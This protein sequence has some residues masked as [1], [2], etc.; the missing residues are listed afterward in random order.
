MFLCWSN[1]IG[2]KEC[3][4]ENWNRLKL[5]ILPPLNWYRNVNSI[6]Y[7]GKCRLRLPVGMVSI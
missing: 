3:D 7:F 1:H 6:P 5:R 2:L 4:F